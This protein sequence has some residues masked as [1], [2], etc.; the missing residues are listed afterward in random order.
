MQGGED[1]KRSLNRLFT[2]WR[3]LNRIVQADHGGKSSAIHIAAAI[4]DAKAFGAIQREFGSF[5]TFIWGFTG[6]RP[7]VMHGHAGGGDG[8]RPPGRLFS[9]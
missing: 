4:Q 2:A 7:K 9:S 1:G 6:G 8:E 3:H 5:D